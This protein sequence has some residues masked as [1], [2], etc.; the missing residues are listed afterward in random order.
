MKRIS[1]KEI[2]KV[3]YGV[4]LSDGYVDKSRRFDLYN[5][6][7]EY[8]EYLNSYLLGITGIKTNLY[9]KYDERFDTTGFR[10]ITNGSRYFAKFREIFY[11]VSGRK[12]LTSYICDRLD[13]QALAHIWMCDGYLFHAKNKKANK[14]QNIGYFC[15]ESFTKDELGLFISRLSDLGINSRLET[16]PWGHGFRP[17]ISGVDLQKFID[18]IYKYIIPCF[19]YKTIL[20]YKSTKYVDSNLQSA[21]QFVKYYK[22][23]EDIVQST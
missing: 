2:K 3:L 12:H 19:H 18:G 23:V 5:K 11:D 21:E 1:S 13:F 10:I 6:N 7:K 8:V 22:Q 9:T 20:Y 14:L 17:K 4:I 16:V 15:L